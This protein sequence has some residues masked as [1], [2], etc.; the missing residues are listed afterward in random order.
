MDWAKAFC[1]IAKEQGHDLDEGWIVTWF[2]NALMRGYDEHANRA[3]TAAPALTA[4]PRRMFEGEPLGCPTPG[5][6]SCP[7][8]V[9]S[10]ALT[11]VPAEPGAKPNE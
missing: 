4:E 1:K 5:A 10:A 11:T 6:C 3:L 7:G 8:A 9:G 2:A